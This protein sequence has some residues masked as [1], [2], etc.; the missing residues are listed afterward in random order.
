[1]LEISEVFTAQGKVNGNGGMAVK[2]GDGA[3]FSGDVTQNG[4]SFKTDGDVV[5]N[6]KS[7]VNHKHNEQGD[8]K[9]TSTPL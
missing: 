2:G 1:M 7:L 3:S 5:A 9:P 8:G 6:G 4:G